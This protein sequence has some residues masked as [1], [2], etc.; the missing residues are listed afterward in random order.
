[1]RRIPGSG[2]RL[3]SSGVGVA[4][5]PPEFKIFFFEFIQAL[6]IIASAGVTIGL[7]RLVLSDDF[8]KF[9]H[10]FA[11][12]HLQRWT[13]HIAM[14]NPEAV[15]RDAIESLLNKASEAEL[16]LLGELCMSM[17]SSPLS[18]I[19]Q[20]YTTEL[21]L[22]YK[23]RYHAAHAGIY[24]R[25]LAECPAFRSWLNDRTAIA[26]LTGRN[27]SYLLKAYCYPDDPIIITLWPA[28]AAI[29]PLISG[30]AE[31]LVDAA[32][33][34]GATCCKAGIWHGKVSKKNYDVS[35]AWIGARIH[36]AGL[37]AYF[38]PSKILAA[39][40]GLREAMRG[41]LTV[42]HLR[43]LLGLL[44]HIVFI[45][46]PQPHDVWNLRRARAPRQSQR[47]QRSSCR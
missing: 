30:T 22:D 32:V 17:G 5:L 28:T 25:W 2:A 13:C 11:L 36:T 15:S 9:F 40:A 7:I 4:V 38:D 27:E 35:A 29:M 18:N 46:F 39:D 24:S 1:M 3:P 20:R 33:E 44:R 26:M 37:I 16:A 34:W 42:P 31:L 41:A 23:A 45:L 10:Q 12:V 8:S 43:K 6:V 19:A 14:L 21:A 47:H